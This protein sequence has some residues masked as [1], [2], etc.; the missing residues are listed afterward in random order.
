MRDMKLLRQAHTQVVDLNSWEPDDE[1]PIGPTGAK[2]KRI[3]ICPTP[4]PHGFLIGGHRYLFKEPSGPHVMQIWSE[5]IAYELAKVVGVPVPPAFLARAPRNGSPGVLVEFFYGYADRAPARLI[6]GI[7]RLV[8]N[9]FAVDFK[10]G[11]L[12]DNIDVCRLQ[13]VPDWRYWWAA[14][15]AFDTLIGNTDRH[16][17][18]WGFLT[19]AAPGGGISFSMAPAFDNG[20]SLGFIVG[21]ES[22]EGH[23]APDAMRRF[24]RRGRHHYG[25][26]SGDRASARHVALCRAYAERIVGSKA[27][28]TRVSSITDARVDE[29]VSWCRTFEYSVPFSAARARFVATQM[30]TRRDALQSPLSGRADHGALGGSPT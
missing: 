16:S 24:V 7:D 14:T 4:A 28:L 3:F 12:K 9:G 23:L 10:H 20:T 30:R 27:T 21:E 29:I 11:S 26:T 18:N 5:V 8:A 15:L 1:F 22:L 19:E 13:K 6:D 17:Q 25:W 2:P